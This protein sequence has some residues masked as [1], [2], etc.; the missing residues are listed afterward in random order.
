MARITWTEPALAQLD[1]I[2]EYIALDNPM[3]ASNLVRR[4]FEAVEQLANFPEVGRRPPEFPDSAYRELV[5][6]P[7]RIFYRAE[8]DTVF[9]I[10]VMR[11]EQELRRYLLG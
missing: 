5:V 9:V 2:A 7:C 4:V 6:P 8:G 1:D 10:H 11:H 3:A